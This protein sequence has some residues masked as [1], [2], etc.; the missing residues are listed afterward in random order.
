MIYMIGSFIHPAWCRRFSAFRFELVFVVVLGQVVFSTPARASKG[1]SVKAQLASHFTA[2]VTTAL[3]ATGSKVTVSDIQSANGKLLEHPSRIIRFELT[4]RRRPVG[5]VAARVSFV[6]GHV[7]TDTWVYARI[8]AKLPVWVMSTTVDR[9]APIQ[10]VVRVEMRDAAR[11]PMDTLTADA[12]LVGRIA[13]RRLISGSPVTSRA[14]TTP[15]LVRHG[16]QV[17]VIVRVG[18]VQIAAAGTAMRDGRRGQHIPVRV[19]QGR[20]VQASVTGSRLVE[21]KR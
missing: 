15:M 7:K 10:R 16:D 19:R 5:R 13:S 11:L 6:H 14:L 17:K 4:Q 9:G 21:V 3:D 8:Q 18:S 2:A 1:H 12:P 20:V